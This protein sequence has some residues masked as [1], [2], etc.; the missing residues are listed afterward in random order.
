MG[1]EIAATQLQDATVS[2][3]NDSCPLTAKESGTGTLQ[4][5]GGEFASY[6]IL[7]RSNGTGLNINDP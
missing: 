5:R 1:L 7:Q 6:L 2:A 3:C 4:N